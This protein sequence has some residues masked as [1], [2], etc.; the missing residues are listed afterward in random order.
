[1]KT[2]FVLCL[3]SF[4][5]VGCA[6]METQDCRKRQGVTV[7]EPKKEPR[8]PRERPDRPYCKSPGC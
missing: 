6:S 7:C 3:L 4:T 5:F 2:L 1:M 8:L